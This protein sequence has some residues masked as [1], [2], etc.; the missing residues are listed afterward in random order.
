MKSLIAIVV[1]MLIATSCGHKQKPVIEW[2]NIPAGT[3]TMGS[4]ITEVD[5]EVNETQHQVTLNAFKMSK[6]EITVEQFKAFVDA[7]GY[8]TDADKGT[9][10][11]S[12][13]YIWTGKK[14]EAK[15]GVNWKC[16]VNGN[17][18]PTAE[19]N[20]PVIHV[21]WNDAKAFA[22]WLGCRLPT[23][24]EWEY[25]CRAGASTGSATGTPFNTGN[26]LTT[27]QAN[28]DGNYPYNNNA[29]GVCRGKTMPVGSFAQNAW[30]L[31]DMHG[32]VWEWC[33]DWYGDYPTDAQTNPQGP[34]TGLRH[35]YRGGCWSN[36]AQDC[37]SALRYNLN[38][39]GR[40][41]NIGFRIVSPE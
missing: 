11:V 2:V 12:G 9:G 20:N 37:R 23:E 36:Y 35:V 14:W 13:S 22:D 4:P 38:P 34:G 5:R 1:T 15:A 29:K 27:D 18:L 21:S 33:S 25:A 3:F 8:A 32:N 31:C 40:N 26:N 17:I 10:G 24:A 30:G 16:D 6:Y 39:D 19:Y 41:R 28:Y 7:T